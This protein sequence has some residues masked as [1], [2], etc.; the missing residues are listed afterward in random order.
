MIHLKIFF[1]DRIS[2]AL[3]LAFMLLG[4][5]FG[6]WAATIPALKQRLDLD[7]AEL[8]MLLLL[9]PA[10][11]I[12]MN[13]G[14]VPLLARFGASKL[15]V[16]ALP[17]TAFLF[18]LPHLMP[19]QF[20]TGVC[21]FMAGAFFS[22]TN[23]AVNTCT[24]TYEDHANVKIIST[25][26]GLWSAGA[27]MGAA[28]SSLSVG[29]GLHPSIYGLM[30]GIIITLV[31]LSVLSGQLDLIPRRSHMHAD[32]D[33]SSPKFTMPN[34]AL[35]L[36][37]IIS[38]CVCLTEGTMVDWSSVYM[39]EVVHAPDTLVGFGY[40]IFAFFM[41]S[42]RFFGDVLTSKFS[43]KQV[44]LYCGI[45]AFTGL[46]ICIWTTSIV[47]ALIGCAVVGAGV[48]MG[49]PM[50]YA[51]A[52]RVGGLRQGVGLATMNTFAMIGYLGGPALLGF[53]ARTY[54]LT[55]AFAVVAFATLI[56]IFVVK[57]KVSNQFE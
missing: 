53:I 6:S 2:R 19:D 36:L 5:T 10:G 57:T 24:T 39:S 21:L 42:G 40:A 8:G 25:S 14:S 54:A 47:V 20:M 26:H 34:S 11:V 9:L 30:L 46:N 33:L 32:Q 48:S 28:I 27:M 52:S 4:Y 41:S 56:W 17:T 51:A 3:G 7:E 22:S 50:L 44:L 55:T 13:L 23:M 16:I 45:L 31:S 18:A 15:T 37:I 29:V 38:I 12:I 49:S 43:G 35:W 1:K